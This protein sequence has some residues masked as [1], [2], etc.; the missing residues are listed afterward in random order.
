MKAAP[1]GVAMAKFK[2]EI[3]RVARVAEAIGRGAGDLSD[4]LAPDQ[5]HVCELL[6]R[7]HMLQNL[8][9]GFLDET[10]DLWIPHFTKLH[11]KAQIGAMAQSKADAAGFGVEWRAAI[12]SGNSANQ[13]DYMAR[14]VAVHMKANN[15]NQAQA[16]RECAQQLGR[17]EDSLRRVVTRSKARKK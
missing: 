7:V 15:V 2:I 6:A 9:P 4:W 5:K 8:A 11:N 16:I 17:D 14:M 12:E 10:F 13:K 3:E 1:E